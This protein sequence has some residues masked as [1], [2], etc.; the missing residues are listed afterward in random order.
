MV[1]LVV[2]E[3]RPAGEAASE[4]EG[5]TPTNVYQVVS[6]FPTWSPA[7]VPSVA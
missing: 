7:V 6:R 5:M 1:E 4:V 2:F 3:D